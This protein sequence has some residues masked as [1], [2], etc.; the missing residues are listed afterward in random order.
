M[1]R[2]WLRVRPGKN[3]YRG[4]AGSSFRCLSNVISRQTL[5]NN[6]NNEKQLQIVQSFRQK[7][8]FSAKNDAFSTQLHPAAAAAAAA[9]RSKMQ[10]QR[11]A[12]KA[13][14]QFTNLLICKIAEIEKLFLQSFVRKRRLQRGEAGSREHRERSSKRELGNTQSL[15]FLSN[16]ELKKRLFLQ[17]HFILF[18]VFLF[19]R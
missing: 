19:R 4:R 17:I 13:N 3:L 18:A 10:Q 15:S 12:A 14:S 16:F 11:G 2:V 9:A 8:L 1:A 5:Q 7:A 6:P